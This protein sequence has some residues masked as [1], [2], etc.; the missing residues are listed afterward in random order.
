MDISEDLTDG[1]EGR[2]GITAT[3]TVEVCLRPLLSVGG[4][5]CTR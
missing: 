5:R 4:T 1:I 3:A 2:M